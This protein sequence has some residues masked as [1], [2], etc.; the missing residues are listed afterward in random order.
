MNC[1]RCGNELDTRSTAGIAAAICGRCAG[2][3]LHKD[4][5]ERAVRLFATEQGIVL[6]TL[7]LLE[8]PARDTTLPCPQCSTLLQRLTLR[9]VEVERCAVCQGVFLDAGEG[10]AL[11]QR[12]V[13]AAGEWD[14]AYQTLL[15]TV[16]TWATPAPEPWL[17]D[18]GDFTSSGHGTID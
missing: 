16:R 4:D 11:A 1:P 9:G 6:K 13:L 5:L 18:A 15:R 10:R 2:A 17:L 8:G 3:C 12:A 14:R 7:T